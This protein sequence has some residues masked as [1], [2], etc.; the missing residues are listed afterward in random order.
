MAEPKW[1]ERQVLT[2]KVSAYL[3]T[4]HNITTEFER[5]LRTAR[6]Y[7]ELAKLARDK[8]PAETATLLEQIQEID[9][10]GHLQ[11]QLEAFE[12]ITGLLQS[13]EETAGEE[14]GGEETGEIDQIQE[15]R[16]RYDVMLE[17]AEDQQEVIS[18]LMLYL[19]NMA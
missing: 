2:E 3:E 19:R 6:H 13:G 11:T 4:H 10:L 17:E 12:D 1:R 16:N 8:E 5:S 7:V 14:S 18:E 15:I 9:L